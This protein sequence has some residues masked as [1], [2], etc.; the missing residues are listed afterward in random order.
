[1]KE[2][3]AYLLHIRDACRKIAKFTKGM[4]YGAF[5]ENELAQ[6]AV[7]REIA[8]IGEAASRLS[9]S[10]RYKHKEV[11]WQDVIG[12]RHKLV[13]GY[14]SVDLEIVWKTVEEDAP[15][16]RKNITRILKEMG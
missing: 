7:V 15:P 6:S 13:H 5:L 2:D 10:F 12:M 16:L 11:P 8:I 1:M 4:S 3:K 14:F 9:A